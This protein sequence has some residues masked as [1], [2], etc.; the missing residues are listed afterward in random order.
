MMERHLRILAANIYECLIKPIHA[1]KHRHD[2][3]TKST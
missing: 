3:E 2:E 1:L